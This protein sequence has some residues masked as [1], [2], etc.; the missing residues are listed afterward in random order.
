MYEESSMSKPNC[1]VV[2]SQVAQAIME[3]DCPQIALEFAVDEYVG[4]LLLNSMGQA[5]QCVDKLLEL[6]RVAHK[7]TRKCIYDNS[8][9]YNDLDCYATVIGGW[10]DKGT[11]AFIHIDQNVNYLYVIPKSGD[12]GMYSRM[13]VYEYTT[14]SEL[15]EL[16]QK[17]GSRYN[18]ARDKAYVGA[19]P[20]ALTGFPERYAIANYHRVRHAEFNIGTLHCALFEEE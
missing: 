6:N 8:F 10:N 19:S 15:K 18:D 1:S 4:K 14:L 3:S 5:R 2:A 20:C 7:L 11:D 16:V 13:Y 12:E 9:E 17:G